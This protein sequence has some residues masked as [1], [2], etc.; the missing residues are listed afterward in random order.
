MERSPDQEKIVLIVALVSD[1]LSI[2][3]GIIVVNAQTPT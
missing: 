2:K 1:W 3:I